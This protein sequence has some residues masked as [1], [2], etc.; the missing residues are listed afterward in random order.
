M[1]L[2]FNPL[3]LKS[4][5]HVISPYRNTAESFIMGKRIKE[6]IGKVAIFDC[7]TNFPCQ[8]RSRCVEEV[9]ENVDIDARV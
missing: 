7:Y 2:R 4:D 9:M 8:Y 5:Q 1:H 6:I 3:N